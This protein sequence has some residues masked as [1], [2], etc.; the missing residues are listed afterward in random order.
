MVDDSFNFH[1]VFMTLSGDLLA[2]N[3]LLPN[4][5]TEEFRIMGG[6]IAQ[7]EGWTSTGGSGFEIV[8]KYDTRLMSMNPPYFPSTGEWNVVY[9]KDRPELSLENIGN[10][11]I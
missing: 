4:A 10:N 1:A 11:E 3:P 6:Y 7:A 5:E 8:I 9:W 2:E